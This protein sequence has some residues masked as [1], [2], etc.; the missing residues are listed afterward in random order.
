MKTT[1]ASKRKFLKAESK[2]ETSHYRLIIGLMIFYVCYALFIEPKTIG[3][4]VKYLLF[5]FLLPTV[6]GAIVLAIYRRRFLIT[7]FSL[8]KSLIAGVFMLIFYTVQGILFS[9]LSFG[10]LA[11][12]SFDCLNYYAVKENSQQ[13]INCD[14]TSIWTRK[15]SKICF[16]FNGEEESVRAER[17]SIRYYK[18]KN[19][20]D[21]QLRLRATKG[22][23]NFYIIDDWT[24]TAK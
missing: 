5:I 12:M 24:I 8:N 1:F 9:Y 3:H 21:F 13:I 14:I 19:L 18:G 2:T 7:H 17:S 23:W 6:F 10:Q 20:S 16:I 15:H 22:I 11:K 4:D